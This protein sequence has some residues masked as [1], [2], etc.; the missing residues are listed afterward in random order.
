[1]NLDL[2]VLALIAFVFLTFGFMVGGEGVFR[3][4]VLN[5]LAYVRPK[6]RRRKSDRGR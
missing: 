3:N 4:K 1:M 5:L 2:A 6:V